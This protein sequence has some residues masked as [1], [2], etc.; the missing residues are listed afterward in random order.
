M[1]LFE[2]QVSSEIVYE[3]RIVTVR[4]DVAQLFNGKNVA[5]E[6]VEHPGGVAIVPIYGDNTV[7]TVRQFRYP[8]MEELLEI[9]AGKLEY[10]EDP[11]ECAI[12]ELGEETGCTA[13][14][15][16][17]LGAIYPSPGYSAEILHIYLA[18]DLVDGE[19]HLDE[20]EFLHV[21]KFPID[22]LVARIMAGQ[23]PDAKTIVG[24]LKAKK[25]LEQL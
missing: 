21:E 6:V 10:G 14:K 15:L 25:Y 3:G 18:L 19:M 16:I 22:E 5:R 9:P 13:G 20:D 1:D 2:K 12:R 4:N 23:I 7:I 8:M 24:V 11:Y 17:Y